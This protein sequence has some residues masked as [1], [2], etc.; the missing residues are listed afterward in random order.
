[1]RWVKQGLIFVP[2]GQGGWMNSHAQLP[3]VQVCRD[4]LRIFFS[5]RPSA[6]LSLPAFIDVDIDDP[7]R[8]RRICERP[9]LELGPAGSFDEHG[10]MPAALVKRE[11]DV[12]L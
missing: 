6:G 8:V 10:M 9:L 4:R 1:M 2:S 7:T 5:T 12:L 11:N 3:V